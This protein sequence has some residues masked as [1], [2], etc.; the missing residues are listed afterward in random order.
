M[1][2]FSTYFEDVAYTPPDAVFELTKDYIVDPDTRKVNLGQGRYKYNYGN[3]WILPAVKAVKE[4]IKD[5]EHEYLL[6][7]GHPEFQRLDT[8]LVFNMASSA[9]RE[10]RIGALMKE[11][12][13]FP[14]FHAAYLG[15]TSGNYNEDA[16]A[17]RYFA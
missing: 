7:L 12:R 3:P 8:E 17:I 13:L 4:A 16:Y 9:I 5:C 6:I 14:L 10:S 2:S 15:L 1:L 11:R